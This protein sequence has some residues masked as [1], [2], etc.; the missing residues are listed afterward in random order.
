MRAAQLGMKVAMVERC[1]NET[2]Q[3]GGRPVPIES[4]RNL[5]CPYRKTHSHLR[6]RQHTLT[7]HILANRDN[8]K[9]L[10][11]ETPANGSMRSDEQASR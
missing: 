3:R 9:L 6:F 1:E 8:W 11:R 5:E 2:E 10:I 4:E 7:A